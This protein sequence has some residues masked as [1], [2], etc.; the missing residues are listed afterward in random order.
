MIND[1]PS[2][3]RVLDTRIPEHYVEGLDYGRHVTTPRWTGYYVRPAGSA[4]PFMVA[5]IDPTMD[6]LD[7]EDLEDEIATLLML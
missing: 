4:L 2:D 6:Y 1:L 3:A 5:R 7:L